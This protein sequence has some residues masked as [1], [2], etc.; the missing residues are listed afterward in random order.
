MCRLCLNFTHLESHKAKVITILLQPTLH[1]RGGQDA[2][3][4]VCQIK[5][6]FAGA[7]NSTSKKHM[8]MRTGERKGG[9]DGGGEQ[10]GG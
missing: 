10:E 7:L 4:N 2:R 9:G 5:N 1:R 8:R 3:R 6:T